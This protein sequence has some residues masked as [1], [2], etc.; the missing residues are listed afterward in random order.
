M[1]GKEIKIVEDNYY[2]SD[3]GYNQ[4]R[5]SNLQPLSNKRKAGENIDMVD[6]KQ[7]EIFKKDE[8]S[9]KLNE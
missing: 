6:I 1:F 5:K 3:V 9:R 8:I 2:L 4:T 7:N